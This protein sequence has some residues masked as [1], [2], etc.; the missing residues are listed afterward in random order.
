METL[1][2]KVAAVRG[3]FNDGW[4][5]LNV[6]IPDAPEPATVVGALSNF[7]PGDQVTFEGKYKSHPR[8]GRQFAAVNATLDVPRDV[9]GIRDYLNNSF[10]WIGP[11]LAKRLTETFGEDL[12]NVLE[13]SPE[14]LATI[15]GIT[16]DRA[17]EIHQEYLRVKSDREDDLWFSRH[18]ITL[19]MKSRLIDAYGSKEEAIKHVRRNPYLLADE[20]WGIGFKKA[21]AIALSIGIPRDSAVRAGACLRYV[22]SQASSEGHCYL[23]GP[24]LAARVLEMLGSNNHALVEQAVADGISSEKIT[25][26]PQETETH[27]Y[28]SSLYGAE[29]S[30]AVKLQM[31]AASHHTEMISELSTS[32]IGALDPDQAKALA[33]A[34]TSKVLIITGGPGVGKTYT[35]NEIIRALGDREIALAAPTGKAAKR[36]SEMTGREAL[37]IHRLLEYSPQFGGF[38]RNLDNPLTCDTLII[39]ETSMLDVPLMASLLEAVTPAT[40]I[41]FVGDV[42]QLPSV[43]P[44]CVL[45]DMIDS[46]ILPVARLSTLHRQAAQSLINLNAQTI[47]R[48]EK[49]KLAQEGD[50]WFIP[51]ETA[52]KIPEQIIRIIEAIPNNFYTCGGSLC[53]VQNGETL[54]EILAR[55]ES[56]TYASQVQPFFFSDI[57]VLCPQ[58]RG[59][60]GVENLNRTLRPFLNPEGAELHGTSFLS[61]DRVIQT[62]NNYDLEIYNGDIGV[63]SGASQHYLYVDFDDL[64]GTRTVEYPKEDQKELQLAYALTIH[65]SQGSEFPVVIIPVHTTNYMMLQ[66]NLIYTGITR[67]KKLVVLVGTTKALNLAIKTVD[68]MSRYS[69]L[70]KWLKEGASECRT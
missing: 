1:T 18:Q 24:D 4:C 12:F 34:M 36:M 51:E 69:N 2:G 17:R 30:I 55:S 58:R 54:Q 32:E 11:V 35:I 8:Y 67:G 15:Q 63:I 28:P 42:D 52:E 46:G 56:P 44:G 14:R 40:Q 20:V 6:T 39:D 31:L 41:I 66:R 45:R 5:I 7:Q 33:L 26:L 37:T 29:L 10:R 47:R 60:V 62:K 9:A 3:P 43:G 61:G 59:P 25:S 16:A 38:R 70:K 19:N 27:I 13:N 50:F 22:L 68:S 23:P 48:G 49:P 57:Q 21:D 53:R 65:K 64:K